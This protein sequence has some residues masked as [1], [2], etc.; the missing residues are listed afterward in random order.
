MRL[1]IVDDHAGVRTMIRQLATLPDHAV[2]EC[3]T[4]EEAIRAVREFE[5]D[6]VTMDVRL[7]GIGGFAATRAICAIR[8]AARVVIVSSYDQPELRHAARAAGAADYVVKD[9]L[10]ELR[11]VLASCSSVLRSAAQNPGAPEQRG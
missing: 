10:G 2:R 4:G 5:P 9:N 8:P 6:L 7:P 11:P 3:A 1:L